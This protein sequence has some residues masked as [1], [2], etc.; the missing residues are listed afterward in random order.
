M[1]ST[2]DSAVTLVVPVRDEEA[3]IPRLAAMI[4]AQTRAPD[5][6]IFVDGG[7]RDTTVT[8]LSSACRAHPNWRVV[9]AGPAT[10]G[11]GRNVGIGAASTEWVALTDAG[12]DIDAHWL[13]RLAS[14]AAASAA[15]ADLD[16]VW[17]DYEM[18]PDTRFASVA[19]YAHH[20]PRL[21]TSRGP[22]RNPFV[23]S[24]MVRRSAWERAG[25]FPDLR[26]AED[27]IFVR[28][29]TE[30]GARAGLAPEAFVRWHP[31][32]TAGETFRRFRTFSRVNA[33]A[34]EQRRW[35]YGVARMYAVASPIVLLTLF[36]RRWVALLLAAPLA[37]S[38]R[39]LQRHRDGRG[40]LWV[41]NPARLVGLTFAHLLIDAATFLGWADASRPSRSW[42]RNER[43]PHISAPRTVGE[44]G[45]R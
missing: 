39:T 29:L 22:V 25:G 34:G 8:R 9:E 20:A 26:A 6:V 19:Q 24:C 32:A 36:R 28:R 42:R 38:A 5:A 14:A 3:W 27:G 31:P 1:R 10:P 33:A 45:P 12:V 40:V 41:L 13:E 16:V 44:D 37:R 23:A 2:T 15:D 35:H 7:S 43:D 18:A 30:N 4:E 21:T 17:G 11:R